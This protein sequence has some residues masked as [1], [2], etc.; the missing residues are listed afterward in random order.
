MWIT[1]SQIKQKCTT[2]THKK[3]ELHIYSL[4]F[5]AE[6]VQKK[7]QKD[8]EEEVAKNWNEREGRRN[9]KEEAESNKHV[10]EEQDEKRTLLK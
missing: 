3:D 8:V 9:V 10:N 1:E 4:C 7:K 5:K 6:Y 2:Q